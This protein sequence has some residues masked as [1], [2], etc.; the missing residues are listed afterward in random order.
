MKPDDTNRTLLGL[1]DEEVAATNAEIARQDAKDRAYR[2]Q[3]DR[4][5]PYVLE[6]LLSFLRGERPMQGTMEE[7]VAARKAGMLPGQ[8]PPGMTPSPSAFELIGQ[9]LKGML[10][11]AFA[12]EPPATPPRR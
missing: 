6:R 8:P 7:Y 5:S 2:E 1:S 10:P 11:S 3:L 4:M 12:A 9:R